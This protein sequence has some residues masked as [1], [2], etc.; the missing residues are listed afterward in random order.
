MDSSVCGSSL[1]GEISAKNGILGE[2][3]GGGRG[4]CG[5]PSAYCRKG[6]ERHPAV[7]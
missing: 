5:S 1:K 2:E 4:R 3:R 6:M 7:D